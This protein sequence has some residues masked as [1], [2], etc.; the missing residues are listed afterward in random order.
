M[1]KTI[2]EKIEEGYYD[3]RVPF[4]TKKDFYEE[5]DCNCPKCDGKTFNK[6]AYLAQKQDY[7]N[8]A[9]ASIKLFKTEALDDV[10]L[11]NNSK[12][13]KIFNKAWNDGHSMG[14][15]EVYIELCKLSEL[16]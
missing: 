5:C 8:G 2:E 4:K 14:L 6:D 15:R 9:N 7:R 11:L 1:E 13:D 16:F 12:A 3:N 10:G